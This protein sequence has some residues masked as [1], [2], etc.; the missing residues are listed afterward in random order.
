MDTSGSMGAW[1]LE[2]EKALVLG[3]VDRLPV[4]LNA[5][6]VAVAQFAQ[7]PIRVDNRAADLGRHHAAG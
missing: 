7:W 6:R 1:G 2:K 5:T 3:A 4:G